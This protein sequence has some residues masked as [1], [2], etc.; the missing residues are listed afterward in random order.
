MSAKD[1]SVFRELK[2]D[3]LEK[4]S[5]GGFVQLPVVPVGPPLPVLYPPM[6]GGGGGG[7]G[8]GGCGPGVIHCVPN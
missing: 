8:G 4:V 7:G 3:E 1:N 2:A 5:G 6:D